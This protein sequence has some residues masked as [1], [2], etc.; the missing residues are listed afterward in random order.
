[1]AMTE[2]P[3]GS[4][5]PVAAPQPLFTGPLPGEPQGMLF[6]LSGP[7]GVGK[8]SV[9]RALKAEGFPLQYVVTVTTRPRRPTEVHGRDY[10]FVSPAE[11]QRL[12]DQGRLLEW[13]VVHGHEY[14]TPLDQVQAALA[15][16]QD[17]LLKIDVQGAA[18]VKRRVPGAV[19][20]FLAPPSLEDLAARLAQRG[21]ESPEALARRLA[22]AQAEL[23]RLREYDYVVI[24]RA[25]ALEMAVAH[26]KAIITAERLRVQPRRT[27]L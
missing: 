15:A 25:G 18:Q 9:I 2:L 12:K 24:N 7:S 13:A 21:T 11:F 6:V 1:M 16:G 17:V 23:Q 5:H 8:D 10:F 19:F 22:D 27:R 4:R 14:G 26:L 20:I 3:T